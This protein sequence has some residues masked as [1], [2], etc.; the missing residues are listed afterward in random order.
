[1]DTILL[2][3]SIEVYVFT[4]ITQQK[5]VKIP[6]ILYLMH[7]GM[8]RLCLQPSSGQRV[9]QIR[10]SYCTYDMGSHEVYMCSTS[11]IGR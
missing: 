5:I 6:I 3:F 1:M 2:C 8:F 11:V 4:S 10:Y 9:V 7:G